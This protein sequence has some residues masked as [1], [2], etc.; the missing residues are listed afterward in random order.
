M[1]REVNDALDG[2]KI[3]YIIKSKKKLAGAYGENTS[4]KTGQSNTSVRNEGYKKK[5]ETKEVLDSR[6]R[7]RRI[8]N[9]RA[10]TDR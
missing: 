2:E 7:R 10:V 3:V 5:R 6:C 4:G 8:W 9:W 1:N